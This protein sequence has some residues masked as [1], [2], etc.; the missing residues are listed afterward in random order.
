MMP[1]K[2]LSKLRD[3][4]L[5]VPQV[6]NGRRSSSTACSGLCALSVT[7]RFL[8]GH[9]H[10]F[11][12]PHNFPSCTRHHP[13]LLPFHLLHP[14]LTNLPNNHNTPTPTKVPTTATTALI[15]VIVLH[16]HPNSLSRNSH[17]SLHA[18]GQ[19]LSDPRGEMMAN[20]WGRSVLGTQVL[21]MAHQAQE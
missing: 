9:Q 19:M 13:F 6:S 3:C 11:L 15:T 14:H 21:E 1:T 8:L 4:Q 2:A 12:L 10:T 18:S 20:G 17:L 5:L 16:R 7:D